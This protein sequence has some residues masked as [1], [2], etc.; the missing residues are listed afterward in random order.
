MNEDYKSEDYKSEEIVNAT[1]ARTMPKLLVT[2]ASRHD[3]EALNLIEIKTRDFPLSVREIQNL[4]TDRDR[5]AVIFTVNAVIQGWCCFR[6]DNPNLVIEH[7]A[8]L[9]GPREEQKLTIAML[10]SKI[11]ETPVSS[12]LANP[13]VRVIW[14]EHETDSKIFEILLDLGFEAVGLEK[15]AFQSYGQAWDGIILE[16]QF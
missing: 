15:D 5:M 16:A 7:L 11:T 1:P 10:F 8:A 9:L 14:P 6:A 12:P 2:Q 3:A 4:I 13:I